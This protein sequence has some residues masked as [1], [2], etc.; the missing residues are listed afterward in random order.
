MLSIQHI[1]IIFVVALVVFGPEKLPELA[2]TIGKFTADFRRVTGEFK[3]TFEGHMRDLERETED[4]RRPATPYTPAPTEN[5]IANHDADSTSDAAAEPAAPTLTPAEGIIP[6][7]DPRILP[8]A[9]SEEPIEVSH[10]SGPAGDAFSA[11]PP[12]EPGDSHEPVTDG[13]HHSI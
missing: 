13:Q 2:R 5:S 4:R 10:D 8:P 3:S 9:S 6:S 12:E 7:A 11:A 1:I